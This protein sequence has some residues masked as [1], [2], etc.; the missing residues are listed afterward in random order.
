MSKTFIVTQNHLW[1]VLCSLFLT[2]FS[3]TPP[4][5]NYVPAWHKFLGFPNQESLFSQN[6]L[7]ILFQAENVISASKITARITLCVVYS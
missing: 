6:D 7:N 3:A 2:T 4:H 5:I 1:S